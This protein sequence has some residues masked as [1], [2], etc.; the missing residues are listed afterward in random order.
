MVPSNL[1]G[2]CSYR[3][4]V[5]TKLGHI[6]VSGTGMLKCGLSDRVEGGR[7]ASLKPVEP[8]SDS[9]SVGGKERGD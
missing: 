9:F 4:D 5:T 6:L 3:Q 2:A 7:G 1:R 8:L